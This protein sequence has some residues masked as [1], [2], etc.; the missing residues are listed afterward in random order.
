[1]IIVR[2]YR[3]LSSLTHEP[4]NVS[5]LPHVPSLFHASLRMAL[6][7]GIVLVGLSCGSTMPNLHVSCCISE[8]QDRC[9]SFRGLS[10]A[11]QSALPNLVR[12]TRSHRS[13]CEPRFLSSRLLHDFHEA[14]GVLSADHLFALPKVTCRRGESAPSQGL[15]VCLSPS[16]HY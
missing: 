2:L 9:F 3:L 13:W 6:T 1:M 4:T 5:R 12:S 8:D 15:S 16:V 14:R 11:S 7:G 10:K